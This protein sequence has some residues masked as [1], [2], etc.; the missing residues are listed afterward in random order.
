MFSTFLLLFLRRIIRQS[1]YTVAFYSAIV[2]Q[3]GMQLVRIMCNCKR[4]FEAYFV[5]HIKVGRGR[6]A[7]IEQDFLICKIII[8][9]I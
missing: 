4:I 3:V 9:F 8:A 7:C 1:V 2:Y 6:G 5:A